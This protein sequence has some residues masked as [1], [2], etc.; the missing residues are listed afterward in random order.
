MEDIS[1]ALVINPNAPN[2]VQCAVSEFCLQELNNATSSD[3]TIVAL[4]MLGFLKQSINLFSS[5]QIKV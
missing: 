5:R 1:P 4:H 3:S 2:P